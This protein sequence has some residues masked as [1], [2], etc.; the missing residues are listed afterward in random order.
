[1]SPPETGILTSATVRLSV[2]VLIACCAMIGPAAIAKPVAALETRKPRRENG[3]AGTRLSRSGWSNLLRTFMHVLRVD[4]RSRS[5]GDAAKRTDSA[6]FLF[7]K[8]H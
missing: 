3:T 2:D 5:G 1:M 8:A 7:L 6:S 4:G